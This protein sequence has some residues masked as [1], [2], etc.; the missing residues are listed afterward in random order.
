MRIVSHKRAGASSRLF[1]GAALALVLSAAATPAGAR[2]A[3]PAQT[4]PARP[5]QEQAAP[6]P[7]VPD[8]LRTRTGQPPARTTR[9][10]PA[11]PAPAGQTPRPHT[12]P[13]AALLAH[14]RPP[15]QVVTVVHR[16]GGWKLLMWLASSR[17]GALEFDALPTA[18]DVH[19]NIVAGYV[20][21]DG[22][23]VVVRLPQAVAEVE[24]A[25]QPQLP[26]GFNSAGFP[27]FQGQSDFML[28]TADNKH[29]KASFVGLDAST[30]LSV[31][32]AA[33]PIPDGR[34]WGFEGS[35]EEDPEVGQP[36]RFYAP[37]PAARS[38]PAPKAAPAH[39]AGA[40]SYIYLNIDQAEGLLTEVQL[41]PSGRPGRVMARA[42]R[43]NPAWTGAVAATPSGDLLGIVSRSMTGETQIVPVESVRRA[44]ERVSAAR[45]SVP[46]PWLGVRG[47]AAFSAPLALWESKGWDAD[48]A[49]SLIQERVGVLLTSVAPGTPASAAG[50]RPGDVITRVGGREVRAVEDFSFVLK[51]AGVGASLD[52]TV[53]RPSERAPLKL[54]V[55]LSGAQ[56][57]ALATA[58]FELRAARAKLAESQSEVR[59]ARIAEQRLRVAA[60]AADAATLA[61]LLTRLREAERKLREALAQLSEAETRISQAQAAPGEFA[62]FK[63]EMQPFDIQFGPLHAFGFEGVGLTPRGG[64]RLGS[65]GGLLVVAVRPESPAATGGLKAGDVVETINGERFTH[66][67]LRRSLLGADPTPVSLGVVRGGR[68]QTLT[69][70]LAPDRKP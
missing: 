55:L 60:S 4:P 42:P 21:A 43:V 31:L 59:E 41:M 6:L 26:A 27:V 15:R 40:E 12:P 7:P 52:F 22:R 44:V 61:R 3:G 5:V 16:L 45:K 47:D 10:A 25:A 17:P 23:S 48:W 28:V 33:E 39:A 11:A 68:R 56:N 65:A 30:G 14:V 69:V 1:K 53:I 34:P 35:T 37:A 64:A 54:P 2:Q 63:F 62:P 58:D 51:D 50:L 13:K 20:N 67:G 9:P 29:V 46:Q 8:S 38:A 24:S 32:E 57:P 66:T 18:S 49:R 70:S 19:T 36:V